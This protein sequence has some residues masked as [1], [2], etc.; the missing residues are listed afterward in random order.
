MVSPNVMEP[1]IVTP[2]EGSRM[3]NVIAFLSSPAAVA[4]APRPP[5]VER[6]TDLGFWLKTLGV[7]AAVVVGFYLM[8]TL[9]K[10]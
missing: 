10:G 5:P 9:G 6:S 4:L 2:T 7:T 8:T 1:V 3:Q